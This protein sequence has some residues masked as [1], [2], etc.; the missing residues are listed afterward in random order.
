MSG[1]FGIIDTGQ[2]DLKKLLTAMGQVM[3][4][5]P[6]YQVE[7][8]YDETQN[9]GLGRI[10]IG[11]F[12]KATQPVCNADQ[13]VALVMAGEL[14]N[15][16]ELSKNGPTQS[17]EQIV[18]TLYEQL[19]D[20]FINRL[21]GAFIIAIWDRVR[22]QLLIVNDR[23]GLYPLHY[24]SYNGRLIFAPEMKGILS[25]PSFHKELDLTALAEYMHFQHLL[26]DKTFFEGLK[27]LPN[28]SLLC[29]NTKSGYLTVRPYWDISHIPQLPAS[30]SFDE[31]VE[32]ASHLLKA[33]VNKLTKRDYRFGVYLS[34]GLDS[35]T[36]LASISPELHPIHTITFGQRGCR[37]VVYA[38]QIAAKVGAQHHYFKFR[39]GEWVEQFAN[40]HLELTEGFHS[41]I[42]SHGI[43]TLEQARSLIDI[44]LTGF[45][46]DTY[47]FD[48]E[49]Y[50]ALLQVPNDTGLS[51]YV[52]YRLSQKE[53]WPSMN[54]AEKNFLFSSRIAPKMRDLAFESFC[55]EWM[56]YNNL[57]YNQRYPYFFICNTSRRLYQY[58]TTFQRSHFE[59]CFP[60][61][62]Y[63]YFE[64][65]SVLPLETF[66]GS[67]LRRATLQKLSKSLARVPY[68]KDNLPVTQGKTAHTTAK[69]IR[70]SKRL[71]NRYVAR[72][73]PQYETL[74][75]D[76]ENWL[77][78]DLRT[79]GEGILL[80]EQILQRDIFN[81]EFLHSL[82][83][84]H[85]SGHEEGMIGKIAPIMTY[86]MMLRRFYD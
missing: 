19:G 26:G 55:S 38:R 4:H 21:K 59:L 81:R 39:N 33:A 5:R 58:Y 43:S 77:R 30:L 32:E 27:L 49:N 15:Q 65:I 56:Q 83:Q 6:W 76:Y 78:D 48:D 62:D 36:I 57:P 66:M 51:V 37:D 82:W 80:G 46:G 10:G 11:I 72:L 84:R 54:E 18:L 53:T 14:Y 40:L 50:Q 17:D 60:F 22:H 42:H 64:F 75:A 24:A 70:K 9:I 68:D 8:Y 71:I 1:I 67:K 85:L 34:G 28:A 61:C 29:Y 69:V 73:F 31:T 25:D 7:C 63:D 52:F 45:G 47:D 74:Y 79:W 20:R 41:W 13:T 16:D 3:K 44:N 12:N 23:F 86:E 35:R 2:T